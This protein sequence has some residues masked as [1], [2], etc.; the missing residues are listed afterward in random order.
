MS[1]LLSASKRWVCPNCPVTAV[2]GQQFGTHSQMHACAGLAGFIAP[3]VSD[4]VRCQVKAVVREDY[5]GR[6][7]V[8]YDGNRRPIMAVVTTR[9]DGEDRVVFAPTATFRGAA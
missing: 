1:V 6:E 5:V 4:G 3:L 7:D 9:D 8:R 2:T